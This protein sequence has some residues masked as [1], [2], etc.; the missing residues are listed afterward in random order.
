M[1]R[2]TSIHCGQASAWQRRTAARTRPTPGPS[3][4]GLTGSRPRAARPAPAVRAGRIRS[5]SGAPSQ[6]GIRGR[7]PVLQVAAGRNGGRWCGSPN[8]RTVLPPPRSG[9][10]C[11]PLVGQEAVEDGRHHP[12]NATGAERGDP[13]RT[14]PAG[15][16]SCAESCGSRRRTPAP[17][18]HLRQHVS[19][20]RAVK[21]PPPAEAAETPRRE[22]SGH[23]RREEGNRGHLHEPR[24][25]AEPPRIRPA[26]VLHVPTLEQAQSC[27]AKPKEALVESATPAPALA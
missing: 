10:R 11:Q 3:Q 17:S 6:S 23:S 24:S 18:F 12:S 19:G 27:S 21:C 14:S 2:S 5:P 20:D 15:T 16:R 22:S 8:P 4:P 7:P 1:P 13:R 9:G 26:A 25:G